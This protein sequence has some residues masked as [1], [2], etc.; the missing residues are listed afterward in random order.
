MLSHF[1]PPKP[2]DKVIDAG[3][4][5][6]TFK[7]I[8]TVKD[9]TM[10]VLKFGVPGY[11]DVDQL[12]NIHPDL[13]KDENSKW[14][15]EKSARF[16]DQLV[17]A[18]CIDE[19]EY[20]A[21]RAKWYTDGILV[22]CSKLQGRKCKITVALEERGDKKVAVIKDIQKSEEAQEI[23]ENIIKDDDIPF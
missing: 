15:L 17:S 13:M 19:R 21:L 9:D 11:I 10:L 12:L 3:D 16:C 8:K 23:Q 1:K 4:Y 6:A 5:T 18:L 22:C 7:S 20:E 14:K 2:Q